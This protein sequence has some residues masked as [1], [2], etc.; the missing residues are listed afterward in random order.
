MVTVS[1]D[2]LQCVKCHKKSSTGK[3]SYVSLI[4]SRTCYGRKMWHFGK[5]MGRLENVKLTLQVV[6]FR[7]RKNLFKEK[8]SRL[9]EH[10][11][12]DNKWLFRIWSLRH[13]RSDKYYFQH[14]LP[15]LLKH[16][17]QVHC[18]LTGY[19]WNYCY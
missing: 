13:L 14:S 16:K 12:S 10:S 9:S 6:C 19:L 7:Q 18:K 17:N 11:T 15:L 8:I 3:E 5:H 1:S 2:H 4:S